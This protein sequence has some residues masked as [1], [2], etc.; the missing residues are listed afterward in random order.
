MPQNSLNERVFRPSCGY[1]N[2][3]GRQKVVL[4]GEGGHYGNM[5]ER[6][7]KG[8]IEEMLVHRGSCCG[9]WWVDCRIEEIRGVVTIIGFG[10]TLLFVCSLWE[11]YFAACARIPVISTSVDDANRPSSA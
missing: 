1:V 10:T 9:N 4:K 8:L 7:K 2:R 6:D 5:Q 3:L 11:S